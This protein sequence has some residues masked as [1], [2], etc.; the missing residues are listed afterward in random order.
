[1]SS[2]ENL[3]P[4]GLMEP[5]IIFSKCNI[6]SES[7]QLKLKM[8]NKDKNGFLYSG[9]HTY[10]IY[11][12]YRPVLPHIVCIC[13]ALLAPWA[14]WNL[15]QYIKWTGVYSE[16]IYQ[17]SV[18]YWNVNKIQ[19]QDLIIQCY[20]LYSPTTLYYAAFIVPWRLYWILYMSASAL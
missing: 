18:V 5:L 3:F 11:L 10:V 16:H 15:A 6:V 9:Q 4:P 19:V 7:T 8:K 12:A 13:T 17:Y 1:M 14:R 20:F 2:L